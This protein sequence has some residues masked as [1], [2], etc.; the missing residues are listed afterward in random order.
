MI[1]TKGSK[2]HHGD[3]KNSLIRCG[4]EILSEDGKQGLSL[5]KVAKKAGVSEAAP[6]RHFKDK[7]AL[8]AAIAEQGFIRLAAL[9]DSVAAKHS[10]D[11]KSLF[12]QSGL[13]YVQFARQNP[14]SMRVMFRLRNVDGGVEYPAL[15]E[16]A[17]EAFS[18]LIDMVE[19]CQQAGLA[20]LGHPMPLALSAWSAVH[21]LSMLLID[22]YISKEALQ[23]T[24]DQSLILATLEI[25][26]QGWQTSTE[27]A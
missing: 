7:E 3:L 5:R 4:L 13:A 20:R 22:N 10:E 1:L 12:F 15:Q 17:D 18:F 11:A 26:L 2:Y 19:Y 23:G 24:E 25:I 9:L 14:D 21:G 27:T 6:Y 16:A 8:V